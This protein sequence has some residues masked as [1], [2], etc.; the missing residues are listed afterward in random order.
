M[1]GSF[2]SWVE[3]TRDVSWLVS[4]EC[5]ITAKKVTVEFHISV[6]VS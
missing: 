1:Y 6:R 5:R 3:G 4:K 2:T